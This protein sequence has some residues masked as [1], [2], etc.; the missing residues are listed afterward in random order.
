V[1]IGSAQAWDS[2]V[3]PLHSDGSFEADRLATGPYD[4]TPSVRGYTSFESIRHIE[5]SGDVSDFEM[6]LEPRGQATQSSSP[7]KR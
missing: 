7:A 3:V 5:V 4:I 1:I 6:V 2:Q